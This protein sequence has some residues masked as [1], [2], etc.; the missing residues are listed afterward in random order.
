MKADAVMPSQFLTLPPVTRENGL[1]GYYL[2]PFIGA[3]RS[4]VPLGELVDDGPEGERSP[5]PDFLP[6]PDS[7][8][9][10]E[11]WRATDLERLALR[12]T[13][14][15]REREKTHAPGRLRLGRRQQREIAP[16]PVDEVVNGNR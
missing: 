5:T 16:C 3:Y 1:T 11:P 15:R 10:L 14:Q 6:R 8:Q 7:H 12:S 9:Y 13:T 2:T 4:A